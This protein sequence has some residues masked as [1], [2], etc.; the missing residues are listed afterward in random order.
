MQQYRQQQRRRRS[1]AAWAT[2]GEQKYARSRVYDSH[3]LLF[4]F[5]N[6]FLIKLSVYFPF[7]FI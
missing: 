5:L 6:H 4:L 1:V 7:L 2:P 3:A